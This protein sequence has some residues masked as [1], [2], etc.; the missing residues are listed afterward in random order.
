MQ[1]STTSPLSLPRDID[2]RFVGLGELMRRYVDGDERAF[3]ELH[4][5]LAPRIS[6]LVRR[7]ISNPEAAKDLEQA[8]FAKAHVA[9][10]RFATPE[11][12]DPDR[13]VWTW[14]AT[15]ARNASVDALRKVY[16]Q[17][18]HATQVDSSSEEALVE[19]LQN[20]ALNAEEII[21]D[22]EDRN[23][24][25]ASVRDAIAELPASQR[26]VVQLHKIEGLSMREISERLEVREGTLRVRAH[27]AYK[28]LTERL[29][30]F[31][32]LAAH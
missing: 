3:T 17:R 22:S 27:R 6:G 26:E 7:R 5:R 29:S 12:R 8:I 9:R 16:R 11:G 19:R 25:R 23:L 2:S 10:Q 32:P 30:A 15:I 18:A 20:D 28:A 1:A 31:S 21:L 24:I 14:Y 13:A 4:A